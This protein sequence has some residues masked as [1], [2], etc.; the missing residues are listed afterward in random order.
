MSSDLQIAL[1]PEPT[2]RRLVAEAARRSWARALGRL[3][4]LVLTFAAIVSIMATH[5]ITIDLVLV[6]AAAWCFVPLVQA[7]MGLVTIAPARG[8]TVGL[9]RALELWLAGY[10]PYI[11]WLLLV[12]FMVMLGALTQI[13]VIL[14]TFSAAIGWASFIETAYCR[15]VLNA[16]PSAARARVAA[17]QLLMLTL[18]SAGV[19]WAAGGVASVVTFLARVAASLIS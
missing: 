16:S 8:R 5:A 2:Y 19:L 4:F 11:L 17:H 1:N 10:L 12:P 3:A 18:V 14:V 15:V 13:G 6:S 9:A 7:A